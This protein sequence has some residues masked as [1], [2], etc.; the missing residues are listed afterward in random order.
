MATGQPCVSMVFM[1]LHYNS[2]RLI[3]LSGCKFGLQQKHPRSGGG[4]PLGQQKRGT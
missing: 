2:L 3:H 1:V 4:A